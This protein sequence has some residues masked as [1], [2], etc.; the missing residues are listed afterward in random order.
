M[1]GV[2]HDSL[3]VGIPATCLV[4]ETSKIE[5]STGN[6]FYEVFGCQLLRAENAQWKRNYTGARS[7]TETDT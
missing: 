1:S 3:L 5:M 4:K 2:L 6:V 7:V